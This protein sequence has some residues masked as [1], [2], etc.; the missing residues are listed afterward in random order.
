[1]SE[2]EVKRR[3]RDLMREWEGLRFGLSETDAAEAWA[4]SIARHEAECPLLKPKPVSA[5]RL[6]LSAEIGRGV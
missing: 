4:E 3:I 1:V 2:R 6:G 5:E